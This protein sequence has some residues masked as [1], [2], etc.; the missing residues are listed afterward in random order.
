M[1]LNN[2][3]AKLAITLCF[4]ALFGLAA[5]FGKSVSVADITLFVVGLL[6][7][8]AL[9]EADEN[10]FYKYY[11][12]EK[13]VNL[14]LSERQLVTRSLL[15]ILS[16][17]PLGLYLMTSTGSSIGVGL[18]INL[19]AGLALEMFSLKDESELFHKRFLY[20]L[21]RKF[22]QQEQRIFRTVFTVSSFLYALIVIF[23]GR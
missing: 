8:W 4:G 22:S 2:I 7:G 14:P 17:F 19:T 16:L 12:E 20:Q 23:L 18:F 15:F 1:K 5:Y 13:E 10:F 3:F 21:K 11:V 6:F 9:L